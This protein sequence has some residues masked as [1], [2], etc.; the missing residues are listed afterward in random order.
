M[1][2]HSHKDS[3][4]GCTQPKGQSQWV[5]TATMTV[6]VGAHSH[7][8][9]HGGCTQP[10]GQSQWVHTATRTVTVDAH[11]HKDSHSGC[12]QLQGQSQWVHTATRIVTL[13]DLNG[14]DV[15]AVVECMRFSC[16]QH[17][18]VPERESAREYTNTCARA[19]ALYVVGSIRDACCFYRAAGS[20]VH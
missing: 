14:L 13:S 3:H 20:D 9:R 19:R 5:H 11:S 10:H 17:R 18:Q 4:S 7:K 15:R 1:G 2:A 6:T 8:D 16:S 12:T